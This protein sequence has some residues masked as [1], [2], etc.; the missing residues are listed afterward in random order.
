MATYQFKN[1]TQTAVG[2]TRT[3]VYTTPA[4]LKAI[5]IGCVVT[6]ITKSGLPITVSLIK[7]NNSE[8]LLAQDSRLLGGQSVDF[9]SGKKIVLASGEQITLKSATPSSVDCLVSVLEDVD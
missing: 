5:A 2:T 9:L 7:A 3:A 4:G 1:A 8:V 6:N